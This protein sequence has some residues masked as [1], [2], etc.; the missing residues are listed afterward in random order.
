[1]ENASHKRVPLK[2]TELFY[3]LI[4]R[5]SIT[6]HL[7][8]VVLDRLT[9]NFKVQKPSNGTCF[10]KISLYRNLI[11]HSIKLEKTYRIVN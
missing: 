9:R 1:M 3:F 11:T 5:K 6:F 10:G 8:E 2:V 7:V 4:T